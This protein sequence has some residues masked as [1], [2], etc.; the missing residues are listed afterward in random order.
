MPTPPLRLALHDAGQIIVLFGAMDTS[1]HFISTAWR[2]WS[3]RDCWLKGTQK[4]NGYKTLCKSA[5]P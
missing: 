5:L 4:G 3:R 1:V 2:M